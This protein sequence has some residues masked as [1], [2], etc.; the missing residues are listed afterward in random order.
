[1]KKKTIIDK[2]NKDKFLLYFSLGLCLGLFLLLIY[3][4]TRVFDQKL[5]PL[6]VLFKV[7]CGCCSKG[8]S[9][10]SKTYQKASKSIS[11][12]VFKNGGKKSFSN[13]SE[14]SDKSRLKQATIT[15]KYT[16]ISNLRYNPRGEDSSAIR[17][18]KFDHNYDSFNKFKPFF[19]P[20]NFDAAL[21][22]TSEF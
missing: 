21:S 12:N 19:H 13:S 10:N 20:E 5:F 2:G 6:Y 16:N 1:M 22:S 14:T 15:K 8:S 11:F 18:N 17:Y 9:K 7:C 4:L 3:L